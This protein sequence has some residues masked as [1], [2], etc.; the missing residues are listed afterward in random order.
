MPSFAVL[1]SKEIWNLTIVT[2]TTVVKAAVSSLDYW[3]HV[4]GFPLSLSG[5]QMV[6]LNYTA[7]HAI[8]PLQAPST[9]SPFHLRVNASPL[10][11]ARPPARPPA[12]RWLRPQPMLSA[13]AGAV[14]RS[15]TLFQCHSPSLPSPLCSK[16]LS[17]FSFNSTHYLQLSKSGPRTSSTWKYKFEGHTQ[18]SWKLW[19]GLAV[20]FYHF[21]LSWV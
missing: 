17:F 21:L 14:A 7:D 6:L 3:T 8:P 9:P 19:V 5:Q 15:G 20:Y 2:A 12:G 13:F 1:L 10:P 4:S 18:V 16:L 11:P